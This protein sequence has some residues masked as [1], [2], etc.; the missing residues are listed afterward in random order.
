MNRQIV[1]AYTFNT[2]STIHLSTNQSSH[3]HLEIRTLCRIELDSVWPY[4]VLNSG[5][6][7]LC[8]YFKQA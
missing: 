5:K 1:L 7:K 4:A 6:I 2:H 3:C 8:V